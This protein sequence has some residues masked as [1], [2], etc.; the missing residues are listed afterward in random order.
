MAYKVPSP[1]PGTTRQILYSSSST[2]DGVQ[3][4]GA[5]WHL[6]KGPRTLSRGD[7]LIDRLGRDPRITSFRVVGRARLHT[8][9]GNALEDLESYSE[10]FLPKGVAQGVVD[11]SLVW[12]FTPIDAPQYLLR[13]ANAARVARPLRLEALFLVATTSLRWLTHPARTL[14]LSLLSLRRGTTTL[15]SIERLLRLGIHAYATAPPDEEWD[16]KAVTE[17]VEAFTG[18]D[19][20]SGDYAQVLAAGTAVVLPALYD[21]S[22]P[23]AVAQRRV[24]KS[25]AFLLR[26]RLT[27]HALCLAI[28][29]RR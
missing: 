26:S 11:W 25:L 21:K 6:A 9:K 7:L 22:T 13:L 27:V 24:A 28:A 3:S 29:E 23:L 18:Q 12:A 15:A 17:L 14:L 1:P 20:P 5:G 19:T 16:L 4:R 2:Q 10:E 8:L